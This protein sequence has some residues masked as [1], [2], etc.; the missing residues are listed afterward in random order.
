MINVESSG[1]AARSSFSGGRR[2]AGLVFDPPFRR[3]PGRHIGII[4]CLIPSKHGNGSRLV[5]S[6]QAVATPNAAS[7]APAPELLMR[8]SDLEWLLEAGPNPLLTTQPALRLMPSAEEIAGVKLPAMTC[9]FASEVHPQYEQVKVECDEWIERV[10]ELPSQAARCFLRDCLL[11]RL[12]CRFIPGALPGRRL[13]Q[14]IKLVAWLMIAD[15]DDDD[16][17][18]LGSDYTATCH[19]ADR[20]LTILTQPA[21][22]FVDQRLWNYDLLDDRLSKRCSRQLATLADLWREMSPDMSP[23]LRSRF[24]SSM[25]DYLEGIKMQASLRKQ[26]RVPNV[27]SYIQI[28]RHASFTIPAFI[29]A[30][31]ASG[32]EL[33]QAAVDNANV[34]QLMNNA[35]D[36]ISLW[37]DIF[38]CYKEILVGDYFNLPSILYMHATPITNS[39]TNCAY[40]QHA[41]NHVAQLTQDLEASCAS[42]IESLIEEH[43][44]PSVDPS[45]RYHIY[46]Y[47]EVITLGM[48]GALAWFSETPRY[49][50]PDTQ[51]Q[52]N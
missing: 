6:V 47:I 45:R 51:D 14:A 19:R 10:A 8:I 26:G 46:S 49:P 35:V 5:H 39:A 28:R 34:M 44:K 40:F 1:R 24:T 23:L 3:S 48:S 41:I 38:S 31:Y 15:D 21:D 20:I 29:I 22:A 43:S 17:T 2:A 11:P 36:Y 7:C 12:V 25:V 52:L 18:V 16:P 37:N 32:I 13:L 27:E 33:D 9:S 42:L 4:S 30:E 50:H